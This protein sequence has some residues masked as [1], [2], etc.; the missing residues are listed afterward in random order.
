MTQKTTTAEDVKSYLL[1]SCNSEGNAEQ[2][3]DLSYE[4]VLD[5]II[6][7]EIECCSI[8]GWWHEAFEMEDV[9]SELICQECLESNN[10]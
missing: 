10:I 6:E 1:G 5:L 4:E 9:D 8:C 7:A 3:F 2:V